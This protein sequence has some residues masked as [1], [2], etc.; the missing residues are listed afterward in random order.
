MKSLT[1]FEILSFFDCLTIPPLY[2]SSPIK[3]SL[4]TTVMV[5]EEYQ[6][7]YVGKHCGCCCLLFPYPLRASD[8][9]VFDTLPRLQIIFSPVRR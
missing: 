4:K 8:V 6:I 1:Y 2:L 5:K 3:K 9:T 7:L